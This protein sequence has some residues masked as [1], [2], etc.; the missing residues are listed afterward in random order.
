LS[1]PAAKPITSTRALTGRTIRHVDYSS[2]HRGVV[3]EVTPTRVTVQHEDGS[4]S[5]ISIAQVV[6]LWLE[7][8]PR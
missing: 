4:V 5:S 7:E 6:D 3:T 8:V 1:A 2:I